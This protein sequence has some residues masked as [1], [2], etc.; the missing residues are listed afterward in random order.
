MNRFR[1]LLVGVL[2][3][4]LGWVIAKAGSDASLAASP[5]P[6]GAPTSTTPAWGGSQGTYYGVAT[7]SGPQSWHMAGI[8]TQPTA[9]MSPGTA[10]M[11]SLPVPLAANPNFPQL[12]CALTGQNMAMQ[13]PRGVGAGSQ[14]EYQFGSAAPGLYV[15]P[16]TVPVSVTGRGPHGDTTAALLSVPAPAGASGGCNAVFL[17]FV[18]G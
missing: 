15:V 7:T 11:G 2:M 13:S 14:I 17:A 8:G 9:T 4:G 12:S 16:A 6:P 18:A 10:T 5:C 3:F 1:T